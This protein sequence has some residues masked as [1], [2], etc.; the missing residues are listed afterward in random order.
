MCKKMILV[1]LS[2]MS[3]DTLQAK[4]PVPVLYFSMLY[5]FYKADMNYN[6]RL[7]NHLLKLAQNISVP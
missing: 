6:K 4:G 5:V 3:T 2:I 1:Y 7:H